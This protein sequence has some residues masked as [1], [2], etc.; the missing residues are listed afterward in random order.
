MR[1]EIGE[2]RDIKAHL[3][4]GEADRHSSLLFAA[5]PVSAK[6]PD[7]KGFPNKCCA[8]FRQLA[9]LRQPRLS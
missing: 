4:E 3:L 6:L 9:K 2:R 5:D 1:T 7:A 8:G